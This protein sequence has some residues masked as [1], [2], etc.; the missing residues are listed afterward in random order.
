[1]IIASRRNGSAKMK[2]IRP[3][4][5]ITGNRHLNIGDCRFGRFTVPVNIKSNNKKKTNQQNENNQ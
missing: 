5:K 1:M 4:S 2:M 3:A